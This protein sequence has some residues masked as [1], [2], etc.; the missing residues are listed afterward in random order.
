[1]FKD[2]KSG[3][4]RAIVMLVVFSSVAFAFQVSGTIK[5]WTT[6]ETLTAADLNTTVQSLKTAVEGATQVGQIVPPKRVANAGIVYSPFLTTITSGIMGTNTE[7]QNPMRRS[8]IVKSVRM[9]ILE[10]INAACT[11][12][13]RK[14]GADTAVQFN[15]VANTTAPMTDSDTVSFVST[16]IL[17]WKTDCPSAYGLNALLSFEF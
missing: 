15:Y 9:D 7:P 2:I 3:L 11:I 8:G 6:G 4:T 10:S 1:M 12:T 14:N 13:L 16:D 17:T 5:T